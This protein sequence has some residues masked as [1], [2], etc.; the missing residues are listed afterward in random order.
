MTAAAAVPHCVQ[1][2]KRLRQW[3]A[4]QWPLTVCMSPLYCKT[5]TLCCCACRT[6]QAI[7]WLEANQLAEVE[8]FEH[9]QKELEA[10]CNPIIQKSG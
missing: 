1:Q 4:Q 3:A 9:Q 6:V 8:E 2:S 7:D 10:V 5:L